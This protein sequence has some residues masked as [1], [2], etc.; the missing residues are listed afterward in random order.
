MGLINQIQD[1][2]RAKEK[3]RKT[4]PQQNM[5]RDFLL[6][7]TAEEKR[8][9]IKTFAPYYFVF[10]TTLNPKSPYEEEA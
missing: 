2:A 10:G 9:V 1:T 8:D 7:K 5:L 4:T 3:K 6:A